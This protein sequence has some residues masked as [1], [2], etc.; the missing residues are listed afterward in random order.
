MSAS[1]DLAIIPSCPP[2]A[3]L[4][5]AALTRAFETFTGIDVVRGNVSAEVKAQAAQYLAALEA[6]NKPASMTRVEFWARKLM[7]GTPPLGKAEFQGRL[8]AIFDACRELPAWAWNEETLRSA[9]RRFKFFPSSAEVF[10]LLN[11]VVQRKLLGTA[12]IRQLAGAQSPPP[13]LHR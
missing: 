1:T 8:E 3:P 7:A 12:I 9:R 11:D 6:Q 10:E 13:A 4:R 2:P 5:P